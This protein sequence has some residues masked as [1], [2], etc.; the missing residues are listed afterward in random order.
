MSRRACK[1]RRTQKSH[2]GRHCERVEAY[3]DGEIDNPMICT[4]H[5]IAH[6]LEMLYDVELKSTEV[7]SLNHGLYMF[8]IV[9]D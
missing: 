4:N 8:E 1:K 6:K 5:A 2:F 9:A 3:L 7:V